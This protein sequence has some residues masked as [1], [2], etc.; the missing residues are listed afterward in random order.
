MRIT[1]DPEKRCTTLKERDLD[2]E[3]AP[4]VFSGP[5]FEQIDSR[6]EYG[7]TRHITVGFLRG[8]MVVLVWTQREEVRH[9]ISMR[10]AN[11]REQARYQA[12]LG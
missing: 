11:G 1:Y 10:K 3:E 2:F 8:R 9:I 4:E 12:R 5:V 7:E 6:F